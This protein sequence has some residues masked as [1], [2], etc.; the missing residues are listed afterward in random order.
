[1]I[2]V[3]TTSDPYIYLPSQVN[4][5]KAETLKMRFAVKNTAKFGFIPGF[6]PF[7]YPSTSEPSATGTQS[8]I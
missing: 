4:P 8:G 3:T 7:C 2:L 5:P 6:G 1:M